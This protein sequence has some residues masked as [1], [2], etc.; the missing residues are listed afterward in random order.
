MRMVL[1]VEDEPSN[2]AVFCPLLGCQRYEI[3]APG[4][5][6]ALASRRVIFLTE[7]SVL[8]W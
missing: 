2:M 6:P 8:E 4:L 1:I 3:L 7:T 5:R